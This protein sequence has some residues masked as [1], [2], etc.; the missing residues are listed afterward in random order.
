[1]CQSWE[2]IG[3]ISNILFLVRIIFLLMDF[4]RFSKR[5]S[6]WFLVDFLLFLDFFYFDFFDFLGFLDF[7]GFFGFFSFRQI[8]R[9]FFGFS[10]WLDF[11]WFKFDIMDDL[12]LFYEFCDI[13]LGFCFDIL[14]FVGAKM[15]LFFLPFLFFGD[16]ILG[17]LLLFSVIW[18]VVEE[19]WG[20]KAGNL[21]SVLEGNFIFAFKPLL[22]FFIL[23]T[24]ILL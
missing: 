12:D 15:G 6:S 22:F 7:F 8:F 23:T 17:K 5:N 20:S 3:I 18:A 14:L 2:N 13:I 19:F 9:F 10:F 11:C 16:E 21:G 4:F 1:M 24:K